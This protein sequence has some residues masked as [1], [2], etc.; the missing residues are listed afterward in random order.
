MLSEQKVDLIQVEVG[1]NPRNDRHVPFESIKNFLESHNYFLFGIYEQVLE[2]PSKRP[3]LRRTNP[4]FI[5]QRLIDTNYASNDNN[6]I[7]FRLRSRISE[8]FDRLFT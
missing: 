5:S 2:W 3:Y 7:F 1:M 4:V 8:V 6:S